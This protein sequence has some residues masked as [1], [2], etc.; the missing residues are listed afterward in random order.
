MSLDGDVAA[1]P[2]PRVAAL[3]VIHPR[4]LRA[5]L[6]LGATPVTLGRQPGPDTLV[7]AHATVSR[8]H[9]RVWWDAA[10]QHA[11]RDLGSRHGTQ[12]GS[13]ALGDAARP[14]VD[15]EVV[16]LGDVMAVYEV[17]AARDAEQVDR[18]ALPGQAPAIVALRAMVAAAAADPAPALVVGATGTGKEWVARELHRLS[19][20][21]GPLVAVNCATLTALLAESQLFGHVK[22]AFTGATTDH[23]GWFRAADGGTLFLDEVGELPLEL[24]AKLLR[25]VQDG[26]VQPLGSSRAVTVDVRLCAAT[27]RE[28]ADDVEGGRF[29]RDLYARLAKLEL[30]VPSLSARRGD[31]LDWVDRLWAAWFR[32]RGRPAPALAFKPAAASAIVHHAW[33][34]N[35]RG[36]D[37]LVHELALR[38]GSPAPIEAAELPRWLTVGTLRP[39]RGSGS[40]E[41]A[42]PRGSGE[43][44]PPAVPEVPE[45]PDVPA[46]LAGERPPVPS[47]ADFLR[48]W[49]ELGGSVRAMARHFGRDR[50]QI[51][52]WLASHGVRAEVTDD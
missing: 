9:A 37:R 25:V 29:R 4:E 11:I 50:R 27:H 24:Q 49:G 19:R 43:L 40:G 2:P 30:R 47:R 10:G 17:A 20:R 38:G 1:R 23:D 7:L 31:L 42:A 44:T 8:G 39:G 21:R 45:V 52:R 26:Q 41:L 3:R 5:T 46:I 32:E 33:A 28:L 15:G 14:L 18:D 35:L 16:R 36:V 22:G 12:V 6:A 34:D 51:Y 13:A 48:M